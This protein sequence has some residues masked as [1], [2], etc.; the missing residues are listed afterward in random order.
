MYGS[1]ILL[2]VG[3]GNN[4]GDAL[5]AGALL[6]RRG[7]HVEALVLDAERVHRGGAAALHAAGGALIRTVPARIDLVLDGIVGI[8]GRG[9]LRARRNSCRAVRS[10]TGTAVCGRPALRG[11]RRHRRGRGV[12]VRADLT[13]TFGVLKPGLLVGAGAVHADCRLVDIGLDPL[14]APACWSPTRRRRRLVPGPGP[15]DDNY[16][17]GVVGVASSV[18]PGRRRALRLRGSRGGG[19][20]PV[21]RAPRPS[22][23]RPPPAGRRH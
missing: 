9:G 19:N 7:A 8:G 6:A 21:R 23:P 10:I 18:Y 3:P 17:R 4:G 16:N 15:E 5:Y 20:G 11:R 13:V 1:R 22:R 12:A 14:D 2:L